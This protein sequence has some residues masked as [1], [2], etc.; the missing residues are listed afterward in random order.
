MPGREKSA[1]A[2][3]YDLSCDLPEETPFSECAERGRSYNYRI[4]AARNC[5]TALAGG[6]DKVIGLLLKMLKK[7]EQMKVW[8]S[9]SGTFPGAFQTLDLQAKRTIVR[10]LGW[11]HTMFG[12]A[13]LTVGKD[14]LSSARHGCE[15][16]GRPIRVT[17][18]LEEKIEETLQSCSSPLSRLIKN[19]EG[20]FTPVH[21]MSCSYKEAYEKSGLK[22]DMSYSSFYSR[23]GKEYQ[24]TSRR[25]DVCEYCMA[26][27][28]MRNRL[29]QIVTTHK[30]VFI[31]V[32]WMSSDPDPR[33][34]EAHLNS[35]H[36]PEK[37]VYKLVA[38]IV[39]DLKEVQHHKEIADLQRDAY[40]KDYDNPP[41][42]TVVVTLD[43]KSRGK[44]PMKPVEPSKQFYNQG[45]YSLLGFGLHWAC[46]G[47]VKRHNIDVLLRSLNQD[48]YVVLQCFKRIINLPVFPK[49]RGIIFW[50]DSGRHFHCNAVLS[51]FVFNEQTVRVNYFCG[52]HGKNDRDGHFGWVSKKLTSFSRDKEIS[53]VKDAASVI[54]VLPNTTA[55]ELRLM[56][57]ST[58]IET[59]SL[60]D[61]SSL[62]CC[63]LED[64]SLVVSPYSGHETFSVPVKKK[65]KV[66][67]FKPKISAK[68]P[69]PPSDCDELSLCGSSE[70]E[71]AVSSNVSS[72]DEHKA[73]LRVLRRK[74]ARIQNTVEKLQTQKDMAAEKEK[75]R[76]ETQKREPQKKRRSA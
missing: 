43:F 71:T 56:P 67:N 9:L 75:K 11:S 55:I 1:A 15:T 42:G 40:N 20:N 23:I 30:K 16:P 12:M 39:Q 61:L 72:D 17:E 58:T 21:G 31:D 13:G 24:H 64:D 3:I 44:L 35:G 66:L 59:L 18:K 52:K 41:D 5:L 60:Q 2:Q 74:R 49:G 57:G 28:H 32:E 38:P 50:M 45:S 48:A 53:T 54:G 76:K 22:D 65:T 47:G 27:Q 33:K 36:R 4:D 26:G 37:A 46:N 70:D 34:L 19:A 8:K 7:D 51:S 10:E 62:L 29:K 25:T 73:Q 69:R 68:L 6:A 14:L 63:S